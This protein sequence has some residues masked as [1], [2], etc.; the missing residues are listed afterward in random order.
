MPVVLTS[1]FMFIHYRIVI[2]LSANCCWSLN[3]YNQCY[4]S[5]DRAIEVRSGAHP[6]S[7]TMGTAGPFPGDKARPGRDADHSPHLVPTS[8][9]SRSYTS[10]PLLRLHRCVVGLLF[11]ISKEIA[12]GT[13]KKIQSARGGVNFCFRYCTTYSTLFERRT[14]G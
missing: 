9:M 4:F 7:C 8:W 14:V 6:A 1:P 11:Y 3:Y 2:E 10:S 12:S 5:N 13:H